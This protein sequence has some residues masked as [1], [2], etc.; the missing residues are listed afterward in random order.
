MTP[1]RVIVIGSGPA[2]LMA[3][4]QAARAGARVQLVE[5]RKALGRK[6]LI[7]GSSGLNVSHELPLPEFAAQYSGSAPHSFWQ[8]VLT[9]FSPRKWLDFIEQDLGHETFL[10]TSSRY[11]VREMKASRMLQSW[12]RLLESQGV[13]ILRDRECRALASGA[14]ELSDGSRLEADAVILAFGGGSYE[15]EEEP[16]R[17]ISLLEKQG[18]ETVP[19]RPSNVGYHVTW[20]PGL[21]QEAE[22]KPI[23][24][25]V[26]ST[27]R[28]KKR[29]EL[30]ITR[31]GLE[32]TPIYTVGA[33]GTAFLDLLP[34]Q[35]V[36]TLREKCLKIRENLSPLRRIKK[37]LRLCEGTLALL[38]HETPRDLHANLDLLLSRLKAFPLTLAG[39]QP[40]A[41]AISSAGGVSFHEVHPGTL[42][43]KKLPRV[44]LA[45]EMLDWDAPTGGFLIQGAVATGFRAATGALA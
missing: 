34:E 40:L 4:F 31:Y 42:E 12:I 24:N 15:P 17:W 37:Q 32:G 19:F 29:G 18:I 3:A 2:G 5:K 45:G 35:S 1:R 23:K 39:T 14:V 30:V 25:C 6:L 9:D 38:F 43:L 11:F 16:L 36:A 26:L 21:L 27:S 28:G 20:S 41:E 22:G 8:E 33:R 44:F 10:G 7:A 13:A